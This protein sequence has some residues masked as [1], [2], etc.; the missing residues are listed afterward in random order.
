LASNK[1]ARVAARRR[2]QNLPYRTKVK[3][4]VTSA[5]A[6]AQSGDAGAAEQ[7]AKAA[8][9]ALDR[10]AQKGTLHRGNA[11]RRKSRIAR[12]AN[13]AKAKS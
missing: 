8:I 2:Q 11:A 4:L 5:R 1:S 9:I 6:A 10:A 3:T 13:A 12:Q 7:A